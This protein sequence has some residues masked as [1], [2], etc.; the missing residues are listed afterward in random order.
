VKEFFHISV[1][2]Y[3]T[4]SVSVGILLFAVLYSHFKPLQLLRPVFHWMG[5]GMSDLNEV[6]DWAL[7]PF[8][9][10]LTLIFRGIVL[11]VRAVRP[12]RVDGSPARQSSGAEAFSD[13]PEN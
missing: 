2:T 10:I 8:L 3:V 9:V 6:V 13:P 4:F 7:K 11:V 5:E 1:E 12:A